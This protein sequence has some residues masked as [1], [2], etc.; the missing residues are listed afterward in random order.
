MNTLLKNE[1]MKNLHSFLFSLVEWTTPQKMI[2][3]T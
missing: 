1:F 2:A 3:K